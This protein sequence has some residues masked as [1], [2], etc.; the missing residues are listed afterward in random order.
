MGKVI[1]TSYPCNK[2]KRVAISL[3][4]AVL[5]CGADWADVATPAPGP[6]QSIGF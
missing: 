3:V 4:A 2:M 1:P 6:T 5:C